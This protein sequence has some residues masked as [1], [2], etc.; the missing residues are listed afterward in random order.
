[1]ELERLATILGRDRLEVRRHLHAA[2]RSDDGAR[3]AKSRFLAMLR[4]ARM[5]PADDDPFQVASG[6]YDLGGDG[7]LLGS[8]ECAACNLIWRWD[9]I[10][11]SALLVGQP[12]TGKSTAIMNWAIQLAPLHSVIIPDL[13]GDYECLLRVIPNA[14]LFVWGEFP[15]NLLR[16]SSLVPA[17][18]FNQ[19]FSEMV[20]DMM[21][22]RQASRRYLSLALDVLEARRAE[23]GHW[24]CLLDL[25]DALEDR[26]EPRGSDELRFRNRCIARIDAICRA[27]GE[28]ALAVENGIDLERIVEEGTVAIFR[29][30][31]ER[32]IADFLTNWLLA[33]VFEH[34]MWSEQKFDQKPIVFVLDEQ[35]NI[36]RRRR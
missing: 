30:N 10:G 26:R 32:S 34:R 6:A 35:R 7:V 4:A 13:R 29:M 36:L 28:D 25:L 22:A 16:G 1:M 12:K 5:D 3:L 19:R 18:V 24:P 9:E 20:T 15:I 8:V 17:P 14:R 11:N 33:Y 2:T 21:D 31:L 23:T 27:L